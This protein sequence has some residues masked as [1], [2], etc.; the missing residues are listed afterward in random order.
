MK[1]VYEKNKH[2]NP[3]EVVLP[4]LKRFNGLHLC[5]LSLQYVWYIWKGFY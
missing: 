5:K 2:S 4:T 3:S 1:V